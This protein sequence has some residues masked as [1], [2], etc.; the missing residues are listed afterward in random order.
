MNVIVAHDGKQ[1]VNR[2][3]IALEQHNW[4]QHFY[5]GFATNTL[6]DFL[7]AH[8]RLQNTLRKREFS[9][10]PSDK[11]TSFYL[12]ALLTRLSSNGYWQMGV[13]CQLFARWVAAQLRQKPDFDLVI[14][15]ENANLELF[16]A[17]RKLR[18]RTVLDLAQVHHNLID[19]IR[20]EFHI[21]DLTPAQNRY[22][23]RRK[24][25]ALDQTDYILT[26]SS[27]ATQ[28]LVANGIGRS[29][30]YEVNL[31]IDP[32]H[33]RPASKPDDGRFRLLFAGTITYRKGIEQLLRVFQQLQ[34]PHAEL[35]LVGPAGD[36]R[37]L[38][39]QCTGTIR[40]IPF[41]HHNELVAYYQRADVFVFPSYLDSWAQVVL[42]AMACGTPVII[43]DNTGAKDA[44]AKGG[45]FIIPT[46]DEAALRDK[47][48][49]LYDHRDEAA[50][51]G[52]E[53][54]RVAE[55]YT[56]E[57]YYRQ[58]TSALADIAHRENIPL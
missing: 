53:A 46:G 40:Y 9:Q 18:K 15:Y 14:G 22:V 12:S 27:F 28:S 38:L 29:R 3:L 36:A 4:L 32:V 17:A 42:E 7:K 26:L 56:W 54:R 25:T 51:L 11:I 50:Q 19:S 20:D 45:G 1:H 48:Q 13:A 34:L 55:H 16:R 52:R 21:D 43:S 24:Q 6:P 10:I 35:L 5:N 49:Y 8:N 39:T 33:F 30:I 41:L 23:N 57:N 37:A 47:I 44:V 31:G 58:V 2:L